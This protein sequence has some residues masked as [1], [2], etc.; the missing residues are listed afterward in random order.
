MMCEDRL[1]VDHPTRH[2]ESRQSRHLHVKEYEIGLQTL[3]RRERL[4]AVAGLA[5]HLDPVDPAEQ[6]A[7]LIARE[8]LIVDEYRAEIH[9]VQCS[10]RGHR[11]R[12][13][14]QADALCGLCELRGQFGLTQS[15]ARESS[16]RESRR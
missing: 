11:A 5:D 9:S 6:I 8:L 13:E 12:S 16:I 15:R 7:Q 10:R 4:Q 1:V 3:Y 14:S 2:L